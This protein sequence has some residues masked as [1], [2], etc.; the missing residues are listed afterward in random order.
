MKIKTLRIA[1]IIFITGLTAL[2][3]ISC[4]SSQPPA[5]EEPEV[6]ETTTAPAESNSDLVVDI[7]LEDV[8]DWTEGEET[9]VEIPESLI[10]SVD[11]ENVDPE[12][13][14]KLGVNFVY[15]ALVPTGEDTYVLKDPQ[16]PEAGYVEDE[17]GP[18]LHQVM[19]VIGGRIE[20]LEDIALTHRTFDVTRP[21][22]TYRLRYWAEVYLLKST[23]Q[24][25]EV[26][27]EAPYITEAEVEEQGGVIPL[28]V[29]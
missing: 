13:A 14:E 21:E 6:I 7:N 16:N 17:N 5:E 20:S 22:D 9:E 19:E 26:F 25:E 3:S 8:I 24:G 1:Q 23:G 27:V 4:T 29:R 18:V 15:E 2:L 10:Y 11:V 28:T 12:S